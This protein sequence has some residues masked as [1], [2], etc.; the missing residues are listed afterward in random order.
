[1]A[2][3]HLFMI[4]PAAFGYNAHTA[5]SNAFQTNLNAPAEIIQEKALGE[6]DALVRL[7]QHHEIRVTVH[8]DTSPPLKP[9]A[10]FPNNWFSTHAD[11]SLVLYPM[12]PINR[13]T[14]RTKEAIDKIHRT[15]SVKRV[16]DLTHYEQQNKFLEGTG[17]LVFDHFNKVGYASLSVRTH[18]QVAQQVCDAL[19]YH[20]VLFSSAD[21]AGKEVYHTNV[22]L[23][24]AERLAVVCLAAITENRTEV[25]QHLRKHKQTV[26]ELTLAQM[27]QFAGNM[28]LVNN[29]KHQ[30]F[31][32][33][34]TTAFQSLLPYQISAIEKHCKTLHSPI[35]TIEKVG[36]GSVRC[37]MAEIF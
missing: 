4:R 19:G 3:S 10:I 25:E 12:Q 37:M 7:L 18:A 32:L 36:G 6:F 20:C 21:A 9:D 13:R 15:F 31:L 16:I 34:S 24:L 23:N 5:E 8:Q 14:E 2:A 27:Q 30:P 17:S 26:V 29:Q 11:G 1:M 33:M 28:L 35:P 22:V